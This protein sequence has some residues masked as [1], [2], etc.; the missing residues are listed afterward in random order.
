MDRK[1]SPGLGSTSQVER[2]L[3]APRL[4]IR[5]KTPR[6]E[7]L[8]RRGGDGRTPERRAKL[9]GGIKVEANRDGAGL[10][11]WPKSAALLC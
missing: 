4:E 7:K 3:Y 10:G 5:E 11:R 8:S 2:Y 6:W 9:I 1:S